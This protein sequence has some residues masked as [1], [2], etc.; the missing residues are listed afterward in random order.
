MT[1]HVRVPRDVLDSQVVFAHSRKKIATVV[2]A[3]AIFW[4]WSLAS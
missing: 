4:W 2:T 1:D 3:A